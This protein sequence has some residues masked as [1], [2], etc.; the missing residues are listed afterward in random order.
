MWTK[1]RVLQFLSRINDGDNLNISFDESD[2]SISPLE[3]AIQVL[4]NISEECTIPQQELE[5]VDTS[6]KEMLVVIC[7]KNNNFEKAKEVLN[8][9]FPK[10]M[11]GKKAI[12]M[13]LIN[14]ESNTHEVLEQINFQ[15]FRKEMVQFCES[16][17]PAT[18]PFLQKAAEQLIDR[19]RMEQ[20]DNPAGPQPDEQDQSALSSGL[21]SNTIKTVPCSPTSNQI[22]RKRLEAGYK[23][24]TADTDKRALSQLEED[25]EREEQN[26]ISKDNLSMHRSA[27]PLQG[28]DMEPMHDGPSQR[29][30][31]SP[32]EAS[33]ADQAPDNVPQ[34]EAGTPSICPQLC[35]VARL[36]MEPDSQWSS[37][38]S[39]DYQEQ[40]AEVR[41]EKPAQTLATSSEED[42]QSTVAAYGGTKSTQ[43][44]HRQ[45]RN[46]KQ[47]NTSDSEDDVLVRSLATCR[48]PVRK[49]RKPA[50]TVGNDEKRVFH[51]QM[52]KTGAGSGGSS[53]SNNRS[54]YF[55][56]KKKKWSDQE[57]EM[58]K[59]AVMKFGEGNWSKILAY[60]PFKDRT[61]VNLKDRWRTMKN[62]NVV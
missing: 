1:I 24:L 40:E 55:M 12:F 17:Y 25:I 47:S 7:I 8:T 30:S 5:K 33:L 22:Q 6:I 58:L 4:K 3:S 59:E 60:Y 48:I 45:A 20:A 41:T 56:H 16:L 31:G 43:K 44:R 32:M 38:C 51:L 10:G 54:S 9:H 53:S 15:Q 36:V 14:Q 49:L 61:N 26:K 13:G 21:Q 57:T 35:N 39:T 19:R 42:T 50:S 18:V 2:D 27:C 52:R 46:S 11:V 34:T 37:Q 23:T 28:T 62:L 29:D